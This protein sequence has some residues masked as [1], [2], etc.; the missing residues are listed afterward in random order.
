MNLPGS[1]RRGF[2]LLE[3]MISLVVLGVIM[4]AAISVLRSQSQ[5]FLRGGARMDL[6]Q[7]ARFVLT[8]VD[9]VVRTLGAG[10]TD[11]QP[12]LVYADGTTIVFNTNYA[13]DSTDGTAVYLNP[14]LPPGAI[15]A[16][17]T[18]TPITIPGTAITYPP[19]NYNWVSGAASR[20]ETVILF[21]RPD[22][23]TADPA[24]YYLFQQVNATAPELIARGLRRYPG[25][26]F[27]E[28]WFDST[29]A[30]GVT[31]SRQLD[32]ARLPIRH[33]ASLHGS[34]TDV[35]ASALAD[36]IRLVRISFVATNGL[37]QTDTSSR[38]FSSMVQLPNNGLAVSTDCG[39][40]PAPPRSFTATSPDTGQIRVDWNPSED[41]GGGERDVTGYAVYLRLVGDTV[42]RNWITQSA[43]RT[44]YAQV[45]SSLIPGQTYVV[46]IRA[47]DCT[48]RESTMLTSTVHVQ[49]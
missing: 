10:T 45:G 41:D 29:Q 35:G 33:T 25:R 20:A 46:G 24:D 39:D 27:F 8:T 23:T 18:A 22:S 14:D 30:N 2:S 43:G 16:I 49:P 4:G 15:N 47:H 9:R 11:E 37:V 44:A 34:A 48:P 21:L 28:Y 31:L 7:N 26:P 13:S 36:S 5:S 17:T 1:D 3:M 42:W 19:R 32:N 40:A 12:M 6:N 38:A